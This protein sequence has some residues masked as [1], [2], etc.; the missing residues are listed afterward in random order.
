MAGGLAPPVQAAAVLVRVTDGMPVDAE[1]V[2]SGRWLGS[3][4]RDR[5]KRARALVADPIQAR[6]GQQVPH[7][8]GEQFTPGHVE[9]GDHGRVE[10]HQ[11]AIVGQ[12]GQRLGRRSRAARAAGRPDG[13]PAA[14]GA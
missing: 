14:R 5:R 2:T 8:G 7:Q 4:R 12:C 3:G 11:P 13:G 9:V 6:I 10:H 1:D